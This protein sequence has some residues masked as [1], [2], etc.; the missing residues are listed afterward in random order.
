MASVKVEDWLTEDGLRKLELYKRRGYTDKQI[1]SKIGISDRTFRR[2]KNKYVSVLSALKKGQ[3]KG[4]DQVEVTMF[5]K[6]V[7]YTDDMG[8]YHP[9]ETTAGIFILKNQRRDQYQDKP[10]LPEEIESIRL[11][12]KLKQYRLDELEM[13]LTGEN[14]TVEK[15]QEWID[16][17]KE[18]A[19]AA[20][21][22]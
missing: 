1:A 8:D 5:D 10:K 19:Y 14:P 16:A 3:Q 20:N 22:D 21:S 4:I 12:N 9:P 18:D 6:A 13:I 11:D 7:G 2:W 17:V 15:I